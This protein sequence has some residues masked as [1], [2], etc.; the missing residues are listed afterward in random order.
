MGRYTTV[1][2][3]IPDASPL[4]SRRDANLRIMFSSCPTYAEYNEVAVANAGLSAL[5][6]AGGPGD[7]IPEIGVADGIINDGG[8]TF[9]S[10]NLNYSDAPAFTDV[11]VG[12]GD[13]PA[14]AWIPNLTS[15]GEG[16]GIDPS[17]KPEFPVE[18][19][20]AAGIEFG[21]GIGSVTEPA[22]TSAGISGQKIGS[23]IMGR[24]YNGSDGSV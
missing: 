15:P 9:G 24:S 8:Y 4:G 12:A 18:N 14:S 17:S 13:L 3:V 7:D 1:A 16:N 6:G 2:P 22:I 10:F 20:P 11:T 21:N 19:L 5:N 23:Y